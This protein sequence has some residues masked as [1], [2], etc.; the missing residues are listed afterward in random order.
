MNPIRE[1]SDEN[2][3]T[4]SLA[5]E[6]AEL[7]KLL[8]END[9]NDAKLWEA[10]AAK[11]I[12]PYPRQRGFALGAEDLIDKIGRE[13]TVKQARRMEEAIMR[14]W[15]AAVEMARSRGPLDGDL[16]RL[17]SA[18]WCLFGWVFDGRAKCIALLV[19]LLREQEAEADRDE[20]GKD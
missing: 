18:V 9:G 17:W 6:E 15:T 5:G 20:R 10:I 11:F 13:L 2:R 12:R 8:V 1:P 16:E 19:Y 7:L 3:D 14:V 4:M